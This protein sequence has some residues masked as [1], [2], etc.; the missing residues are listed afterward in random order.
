MLTVTNHSKSNPHLQLLV[1]SFLRQKTNFAA[2]ME[3][4]KESPSLSMSD[5][6]GESSNQA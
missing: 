2:Y 1:N 5:H 3:V 6:F 4:R